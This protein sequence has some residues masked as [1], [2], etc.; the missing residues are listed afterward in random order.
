M[1]DYP[2]GKKIIICCNVYPPNF[3]GGAE[4]IAH[5]HAKVLKSLGYDVIIF[6]GDT[7]G[8]GERH[9]LRKETYDS[10]TVYRVTLTWEDF[11]QSNFNFTHKRVEEHFKNILDS[12][13]P[14]IA[15]FHNIIGL[16][17]GLIHIAKRKGLKTVLTLHDYWGFCYKNTILKKEDKICQD[18]SKC[19]ECMPYVSE[20]AYKNIPI[21]MR[22]DFLT[23][24]FKNV[25][26]FISPGHNR[27]NK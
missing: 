3:I 25:D 12:F 24:Q 22:N 15:H 5:D 16:S 6:A 1:S 27:L 10:L 23:I 11:H 9:S 21:S 14:N 8:H 17:V 13:S 19:A 26:V 18:Y 7:Q 20:G 4:L 2:M